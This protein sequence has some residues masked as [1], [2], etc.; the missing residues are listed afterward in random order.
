M[1]ATNAKTTVANNLTT[2]VTIMRDG[3]LKDKAAEWA[4]HSLSPEHI[5]MT[6]RT[7]M[8]R[9]AE[10]P[11][12]LLGGRWVGSANTTG[13]FIY[14]FNRNVK[15]A[16]ITPF[17]AALISLLKRGLMVLAQ[18]WVWTQLCNVPVSDSNGMVY[19]S[20]KLTAEVRCNAVMACVLLC[21]PVQWQQ[22]PTAIMGDA[23]ATALM[24]IVD[25][26]G[27]LVRNILN[28][29]IHMF[30]R[31]VKF[32]VAGNWPVLIQCGQCHLLG[33]NTRSPLCKTPPHAVRC[34]KCGSPHQAQQ[35]AFY[36]KGKHADAR[37]CN[38]K[39]KCILCGNVGHHARSCQCPK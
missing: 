4:I 8:E 39:L 20:E 18:G 15:F 12:Y 9:T 6:A 5:V 28:N 1:G 38:C 2:E 13:N 35:H 10:F 19:D 3:G 23:S 17:G 37:H 21:M 34:Y 14:V 11:P 22:N 16:K 24:P 7:A 26:D 30:G 27:S 36:C 33:H 31:Q 29:N 32:V 25:E